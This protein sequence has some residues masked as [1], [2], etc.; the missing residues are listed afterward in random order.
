VP[1]QRAPARGG[2]RSHRRG[3]RPASA[4]EVP[5]QRA[6]ARGGSRSH[7]RGDRPAGAGERAFVAA[8]AGERA[9][10]G[11]GKVL[12]SGQRRGPF[13][14]RVQAR[15]PLGGSARVGQ[16]SCEANLTNAQAAKFLP[17][18]FIQ[19]CSRQLGK[20]VMFSSICFLQM[21]PSENIA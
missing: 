21:L 4:G 17:S 12:G 3:G 5:I 1:I 15:P 14:R 11:A 10:V 2:S 13:R 18:A 8:G 9:F 6:P 19:S 7:Q 20:G 16:Q